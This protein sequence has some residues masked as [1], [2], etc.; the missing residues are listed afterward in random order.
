MSDSSSVFAF[1]QS[2]K[3]GAHF[4]LVSHFGAEQNLAVGVFENVFDDFENFCAVYFPAFRHDFFAS[5]DFPFRV[6]YAPL[7][8][9]GRVAESRHDAHEF[10][11]VEFRV[12]ICEKF[13]RPFC[14]GDVERECRVG[15]K[16]AVRVCDFLPFQ[17]FQR[18]RFAGEKERRVFDDVADF[19]RDF[20]DCDSEDPVGLLRVPAPRLNVPSC[21]EVRARR[22]DE[23]VAVF[24]GVRKGVVGKP[25]V[26]ADARRNGF[27][28]GEI[29]RNHGFYRGVGLHFSERD[30]RVRQKSFE[31]ADKPD[32]VR[33]VADI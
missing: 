10:A 28:V 30:F 33:D 25:A 22:M 27:H 3:L 11:V 9:V 14:V 17:N 26:F 2:E 13:R 16:R 5:G 24:C 8:P 1:E 32:G 21:D 7:F 23:N 12:G 4:A 15:H 19:G 20:F 18:R 31:Y 6:A 29:S